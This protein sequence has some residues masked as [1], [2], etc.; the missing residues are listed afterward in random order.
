LSEIETAQIDAE[1]TRKRKG[2]MAI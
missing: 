2:V 1:E